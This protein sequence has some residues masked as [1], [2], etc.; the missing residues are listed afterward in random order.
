M[1]VFCTLSGSST[2]FSLRYSSAPSL[3]TRGAFYSASQRPLRVIKYR[4][5]LEGLSLKTPVFPVWTSTQ[6]SDA[7]LGWMPRTQR[8]CQGG[9]APQPPALLGSARLG[10]ARSNT[11]EHGAAHTD[12]ARNGTARLGSTPRGSARP[13]RTALAPGELRPRWASGAPAQPAALPAGA[14]TEQLRGGRPMAA[15]RGG[16]GPAGPARGR[17]RG[18]PG[19][20]S[21]GSGLSPRRVF[22][23]GGKAAFRV[24]APSAAAPRGNAARRA[25][26]VPQ[27]GAGARR[28]REL[29]RAAPLRCL[30][31]LKPLGNARRERLGWDGE[32]RTLESA[33]GF[34]RKELR[35]CHVFFL[36]VS[37]GAAAVGLG[38]ARIPH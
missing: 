10:S 28:A 27:R 29:P 6:R 37:N 11:A 24:R 7:A 5:R 26:R 16:G 30:S 12:Q 18:S 2:V 35:Q 9:E 20:G 14:A 36:K 3:L 21:P 25:V 4:H 34:V 17:L 32:M 23:G 1:A 13:P 8:G 19:R 31:S 33:S 15:P 38:T 22:H